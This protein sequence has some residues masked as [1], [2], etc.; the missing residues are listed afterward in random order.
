MVNVTALVTETLVDAF[1]GLVDSR[2]NDPLPNEPVPVVN[3]LA[4]VVTLKFF[5]GLTNDEVAET[6]G[7]TE[8]TI[9][10]KW[11]YAK[12][13]LLKNIRETGDVQL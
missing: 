9:C 2:V 13:W 6:L 8:R 12:V 4:K 10:N 1:A 11:A 3:E 7:V 5:G